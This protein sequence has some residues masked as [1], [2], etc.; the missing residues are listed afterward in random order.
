MDRWG[1]G[2]VAGRVSLMAHGSLPFGDDEVKSRVS[3]PLVLSESSGCYPPNRSSPPSCRTLRCS[4]RD[5]D[6]TGLSGRAV[7]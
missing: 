5:V 7:H 6:E 3:S 4:A 1:L 2:E